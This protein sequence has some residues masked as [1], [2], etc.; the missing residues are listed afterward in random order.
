M[1]SL[2][3]NLPVYNRIGISTGRT[4]DRRN[5]ENELHLALAKLVL[6]S[7]ESDGISHSNLG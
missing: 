1:S 4:M 7:T 2:P 6:T 3:G 5:E